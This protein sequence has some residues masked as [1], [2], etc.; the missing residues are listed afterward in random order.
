MKI[1][2][3][4]TT[5]PSTGFVRAQAAF[6]ISQG[7]EVHIVSSPGPEL[8]EFETREQ[9]IIHEIPMMRRISPWCDLIAIARMFALFRGEHP[10]IVHAHTPKATLLAMLAARMA[11]VPCRI[12]HLH[13]LP[14][15]TATGTLRFILLWST[16]IPALLATQ[17]ASVSYS[18][19]ASA[20]DERICG[21]GKSLVFENG[22]SNGV[23]A[24][25]RFNPEKHT[26]MDGIRVLGIE[27]NALVIGFAGRLVR[28]KGVVDLH[29]AWAQ[30]RED[31]PNSY[32]LIAG[33]RDVRDALPEA[34]LKSLQSDPRVKML[35]HFSEMPAF[36]AGLDLFVLP[37]YRE[38]MPTVILEAA[39]MGIPTVA[40]RCVGCVD[41]VVDGVTGT[42]VPPGDPVALAD[43]IRKYFN[44]P[45]L[46]RQHGARARARVLRDF[47]P[48]DLWQATLRVYQSAVSQH[49]PSPLLMPKGT[50]R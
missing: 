40:S 18:V 48:E 42:L 9:V 26:R 1:F 3:V 39:A 10:D 32:L 50:N 37:T 35:G 34:V 38:G 16:K 43:A 24:M 45:D 20:I 49:V 6:I 11:R 41:A 21:A 7:N 12:C 14:H 44:N 36:Y 13:G 33:D 23:D 4:F 47:R 8:T 30:I 22:S 46:R 31:I 2:H 5:S 29:R 15:S 27:E 17:V 19:E 28:D 25:D